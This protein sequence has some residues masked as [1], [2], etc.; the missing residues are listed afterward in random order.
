[1]RNK[2][3]KEKVTKKPVL[4]YE[5]RKSKYSNNHNKIIGAIG[6]NIACKYLHNTGWNIIDRNIYF[7][8]GELDI[9]ASLETTLVFFEVK[10]RTNSSF[11]GSINSIT[12]K[13]LS[14]LEKLATQ[15][16]NNNKNKLNF[17]TYR[18]DAILIDITPSLTG[19][20]KHIKG[21]RYGK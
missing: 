21:I 6:E 20:I 16:L 3:L 4:E 8:N 2:K 10:T 14:T 5:Q 9:V 11:G 1:M 19:V 12:S 7:N 18:I 17:N 13:K 15:W